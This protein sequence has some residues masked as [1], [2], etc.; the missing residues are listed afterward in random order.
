MRFCRRFYR[1]RFR[2]IHLTECK[3]AM[4]KANAKKLTQVRRCFIHPF[5]LGIFICFV[6]E[7]LCPL[8]I[9]LDIFVGI[10]GN[11][12]FRHS[13]FYKK[14]RHKTISLLSCLRRVLLKSKEPKTQGVSEPPASPTDKGSALDPFDF[15]K[16]KYF[17]RVSLRA[18]GVGHT[19]LL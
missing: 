12:D 7:G 15:C 1:F 10:V 5:Y 9:F 2:G 6:G 3:S 13:V 8:P 4:R 19:F 16:Q 14:Y 17:L 18:L 11:G